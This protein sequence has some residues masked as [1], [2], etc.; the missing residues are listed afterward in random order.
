MKQ[1]FK[2]FS[3]LRL[4]IVL[5]ALSMVMVF[6]GTLDQVQW[7]IHHTQE[8][9]FKSWLVFSPVLSLAAMPFAHSYIEALEHIRVPLPGGF[10]LGTLLLANLMCAHFRYFRASWK[11]AGIVVIHAGVVLLLVS[12]FT[13][14][15]LQK[16]AQM[17]IDEGSR[18]NYVKSFRENELAVIDKSGKTADTVYSIPEELIKDAAIAGGR[19]RIPGTGLAVEPLQY[20][21]NANMGEAARNP[22]GGLPMDDVNRG[23]AA[24]TP[25]KVFPRPRS[26]D[27]QDPNVATAKVRLL[28]GGESMGTWLVSNIMEDGPFPPQTFTHE[29]KEWEVSLRRARTYLPYWIALDEFKHERYPGSNIPKN[30]QSDV[31]IINPDTGENRRAT[32]KMNQPLRY[33]GLAFYQHQA[34]TG[35]NLERSG[36]QVVRNEGWLLPYIAIFLVGAGMVVQFV[37]SLYTYQKRRSGNAA[38]TVPGPP[39][40]T[41]G[42]QDSHSPNGHATEEELEPVTPTQARI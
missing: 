29:G 16:E 34:F 6:F 18:T 10:T 9:Y 12:G 17:L 38:A 32:I 42:A 2:L 37:T 36:L 41:P 40:A 13:T 33:A 22:H 25:V 31:R 30:F 4:T 39:A 7:G 35:P 5:L 28:A 23:F 26:Y 19:V 15:V 20:F 21:P 14:A 8:L 27:D 1:M 24:R 3:S 11:K